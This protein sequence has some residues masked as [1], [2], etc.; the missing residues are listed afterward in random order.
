[1]KIAGIIKNDVVNGYD[2]CVSVWVQGCPFR[3]SGC[4]NPSTWDY[5]G[6]T[7]V[8]EEEII[9][10]T[11][12]AISKNGIQRNLS[13][14]GGEPLCEHNNLFVRKLIKTARE[15]YPDIKVYLWTGFYVGELNEEQ[16]ITASLTDRIIDG[17]FEKDLR[18]ITLPFRGSG[19]QRI[20]DTSSLASGDLLIKDDLS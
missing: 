4:H 17:R 5:N 16:M 7:E 12:D 6:G 11:I 1:M 2:V 14:L 10:E 8:T 19:N 18:D 13:I 20:I 15:K 9:N 3:C